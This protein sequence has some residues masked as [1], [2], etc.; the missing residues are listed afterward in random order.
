VFPFVDSTFPA[1]N[2]PQKYKSTIC[3]PI[4]C[5]KVKNSIQIYKIFAKKFFGGRIYSIQSPIPA[6]GAISNP[7]GIA[8]AAQLPQLPLLRQTQMHRLVQQLFF[9]FSSAK[10]EM[11]TEPIKVLQP[12]LS[13][14]L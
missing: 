8:S 3:R 5:L 10:L 13:T 11:L 4:F 14:M 1:C 7:A 12:I 9:F 2:L 6:A